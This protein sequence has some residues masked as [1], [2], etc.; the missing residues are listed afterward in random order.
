MLKRLLVTMC[1][2]VT[3]AA[4]AGTVTVNGTN[5]GTLKSVTISAVGDVVVLT[6]E[7][8]PP[9]VDPPAPDPFACP[10]GVTCVERPFPN[11]Q[12]E[13][14]AMR[15]GQV[16]A[17]KIAVPASGAGFINTMTYAGVSAT[18]VVALSTVP[19][20][21]STTSYCSSSG[22]EATNNKWSATSAS[23]TCVLPSGKTAFINIK[24]TNC[25]QGQTCKFYLKAN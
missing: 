25:P 5:M 9:P 16:L 1:L 13:V 24:L 12:Q 7:G 14:V 18:R 2:A 11:I 20:E 10:A 19:G 22:L 6:G 23:R 17:V 15:A 21:F 3:G 8:T 4:E